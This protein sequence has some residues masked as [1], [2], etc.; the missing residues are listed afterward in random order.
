MENPK[1]KE[2]LGC[3]YLQ[4]KK[5]MQKLFDKAKGSRV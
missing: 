2:I 1:Q 4:S 5:R 3:G